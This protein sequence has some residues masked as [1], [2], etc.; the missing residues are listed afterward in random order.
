MTFT[1]TKSV[2]L[3]VTSGLLP[4]CNF[5]DDLPKL[6]RTPGTDK[7]VTPPTTERTHE[8]PSLRC[9]VTLSVHGV[10]RGRVVMSPPE[11]LWSPCTYRSGWLLCVV[12]ITHWYDL[13]TT[14]ADSLRLSRPPGDRN[15]TSSLVFV[16]WLQTTRK[17]FVL[18]RHLWRYFYWLNKAIKRNNQTRYGV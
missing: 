18:V 8:I 11:N 6:G 17:S 14:T 13:Q 10:G 9:F 12:K 7:P 16:R 15:R 3:F 2:D 5:Y 1:C 4:L